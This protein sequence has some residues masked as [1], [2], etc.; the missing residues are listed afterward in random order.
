MIETA[1]TN[2]DY[3]NITA[4][5][6]GRMGVRLIDPGNVVRASDSGSIATLTQMQPVAVLFTLPAR[7]LQDVRDA[8]AGGPVEVVAFDPDNRR[9]LSTGKLLL[10]DNVIDQSTATIRLK[11][12]RSSKRSSTGSLWRPLP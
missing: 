7:N 12:A 4:P 9:P 10:I 3:T 11:A 8:M 1:Q 6:D 5:S 2:L